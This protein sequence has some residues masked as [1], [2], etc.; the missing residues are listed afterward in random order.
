MSVQLD[1]DTRNAMLD[2]FEATVGADPTLEL[3]TGAPPANCA[4]ADTGTL[5]A[6][7]GLPADWMGA[8][9]AGVKSKSGVWQAIPVADG[10]AGHF[11]LKSSGGEV[12]M[13]GTVSEL[14]A[15]GDLELQQDDVAI[16]TARTLTILAF[17]LTGAHG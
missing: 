16:T 1:V 3:R 5:L 7:V 17:S 13:Q 8:A 4:A 9:A 6:D 12:R 11:R 10:D 15:G 2:A 14:G